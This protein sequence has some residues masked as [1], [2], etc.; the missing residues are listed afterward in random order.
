MRHEEKFICSQRQLACM[1][2]RLRAVMPY[3]ENQKGGSY[4]I[5]SLYFDTAD[6]RLYEESLAG[7]DRRRKYRIRFY[8]M[9]EGMFR[10][11]RKDTVGRLKEK[12]SALIDGDAVAELINGGRL[13]DDEDNVL[14]ELYVLQQ[15]EG[16]H[17]VAVVDYHRTA[18]TYPVGNVR[19]TL[20]RD[21]ACTHRTADLLDRHALLYPL[22]PYGKHVLEVKYDSILPGFIASLID[23]G[24]LLQV[25]FS[26]YAY[27][28]AVMNGN[29]RKEDGYEL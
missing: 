17:P 28:R 23:T 21:M 22:L 7:V 20:D 16:L 18:F 4:H 5:R 29:G 1:E 8:D 14:H 11:E 19:I 9:D 25:S 2:S 15:S 24:D 12:H 6:D 26:K 13:S 10:A 27:A 3:D